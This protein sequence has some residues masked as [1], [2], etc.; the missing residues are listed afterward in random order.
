MLQMF[1][2]LPDKVRRCLELAPSS[3]NIYCNVTDVSSAS[4]QSPM[5]SLAGP[6]IPEHLLCIQRFQTTPDGVS[7]W[8][9]IPRTFT[10][11]LQMY[12][13][14]PDKV[15]QCLELAHSFQKVYCNVTYVPSVSRQSPTV[16]LAGP[17]FP[18]RLL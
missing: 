4:R 1:L 14:L 9:T 15:R 8:P 7:S 10:V 18:E 3:Q 17:Q 13:A 6:Q 11:M 5:V 12:P 16:S 2:A